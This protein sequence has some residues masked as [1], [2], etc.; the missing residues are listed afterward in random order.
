M[1][2]HHCFPVCRFPFADR[3]LGIICVPG[4]A[5]RSQG[6][7]QDL[8]SWCPCLSGKRPG[9][10]GGAASRGTWPSNVPRGALRLSLPS[11]APEQADAGR[12]PTPTPNHLIRSPPNSSCPS[13]PRLWPP[14][15]DFLS[16]HTRSSH[17][18]QLVLCTLHLRG[19]S[20]PWEAQG[21]DRS[22]SGTRRVVGTRL[23][24]AGVGWRRVPGHV[25]NILGF[26]GHPTPLVDTKP[27]TKC[28]PRS[29][30]SLFI[31]A[32]GQQ[33]PTEPPPPQA[34]PSHPL[35][36]PANP[37]SPRRPH[38]GPWLALSSSHGQ[39]TWP[40]PPWVPVM[41][42][43]RAVPPG[44]PFR[45]EGAWSPRCRLRR[46]RRAPPLPTA[47]PP[48]SEAGLHLTAGQGVAVEGW[49]PRPPQGS[50]EGSPQ[51][52]NSL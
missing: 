38:P 8:C 10:G 31:K 25:A 46:R 40:P 44:F 21:R 47:S 43:H 7:S 22:P 12:S 20:F 18:R 23:G 33:E 3:S 6:T 4:F 52:P 26:V 51:L 17:T 39:P 24:G 34:S 28:K 32:G 29:N 48:P 42:R 37:V 35:L 13:R 49:P 50:S 5:P 9:E 30:K 11:H 16:S 2:S 45:S 36:H 27:Q 19:P 1:W 41:D 15:P 14:G